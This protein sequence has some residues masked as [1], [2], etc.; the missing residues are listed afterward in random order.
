MVSGMSVFFCVR[1]SL[2]SHLLYWWRRRRSTLPKRARGCH[3]RLEAAEPVREG[4]SA[5]GRW[6]TGV[7]DGA[8]VLGT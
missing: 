2:L 5:S 1:E 3:G 8:A 7:K 6:A 4:S